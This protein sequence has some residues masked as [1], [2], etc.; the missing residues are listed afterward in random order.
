MLVMEHATDNYSLVMF[1]ITI[2]VQNFFFFKFCIDSL[3]LRV[4]GNDLLGGGLCSLNAF[5]VSFFI[6][7]S[8]LS[9]PSPSFAAWPFK[10]KTVKHLLHV[11]LISNWNK[12][13][14]VQ[15]SHKHTRFMPACPFPAAAPVRV[16]P[17]SRSTD[18]PF[19]LFKR[20]RLIIFFS[21]I[22]VV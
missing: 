2:W 21:L 19:Y 13:C 3:S 8:K 5:L 22:K 6:H 18:T 7:W 12:N 20:F 10:I 9:K 17:T 4:Q 15:N 1:Q 16:S 11:S 14:T